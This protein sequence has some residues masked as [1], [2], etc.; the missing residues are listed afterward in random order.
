MY[1]Y[2]RLLCVWIMLLGLALLFAASDRVASDA[3]EPDYRLYLPLVSRPVTVQAT[4]IK[5][6]SWGLTSRGAD[7]A[8]ATQ[9][10]NVTVR[11]ND[12]A[13][14]AWNIGPWHANPYTLVRSF[15]AFDL[16]N[17]PA[18]TITQAQ[19]ELYPWWISVS[20]PVE[21]EIRRGLWTGVPT[22]T[23]WNAYGELLA[24]VTVTDTHTAIWVPLALEDMPVP[25]TLYL[26]LRSPEHLALSSYSETLGAAF[27]LSEMEGYETVSKLHLWII[28]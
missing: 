8:E 11:R 3:L 15:T 5:P 22:A 10:A 13:M 19:L 21:I 26:V 2:A 14:A 6:Q 12:I 25:P 28:P 4:F 23:D 1:R 18:G 24:T 7:W 27:G 16:T 20:S 17:A 9:A